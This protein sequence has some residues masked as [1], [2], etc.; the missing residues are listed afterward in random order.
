MKRFRVIFI[1][2]ALLYMA[3]LAIAI[4]ARAQTEPVTFSWTNPTSCASGLELD[5]LIFNRFEL[6]CGAVPG[7]RAGSVRSWIDDATTTRTFTDFATGVDTFCALRVDCISTSSIGCAFS[8]FSNE[9]SFILP[10]P[11]Q[12]GPPTGLS[13]AVGDGS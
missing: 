12:P 1:A 5:C 10:T 4:T 2:G 9:V 11:T 6:G 8:A 3:S 13:V 7:D